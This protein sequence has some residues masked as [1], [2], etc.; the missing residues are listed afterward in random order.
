MRT[1]KVLKLTTIITCLALAS[2]EK[3]EKDDSANSAIIS[4][5]DCSTV[6]TNTDGPKA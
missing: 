2:C 4:N 6:I 3:K 1:K 5:N